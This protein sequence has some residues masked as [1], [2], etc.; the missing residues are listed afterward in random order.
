MKHS[1]FPFP[2]AARSRWL[3]WGAGLACAAVLAGCATTGAQD[4]SPEAQV[5]QRSAAYLKARQAGEVDKAYALLAPSY[6][7]V[8]NQERF[9]LEQGAATVLR[10]GDLVSAKCEETRCQVLRNYRTKVPM[11]GDAEVPLSIYETWVSEDGQW[12]LFME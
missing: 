4:Q 1:T 8:K 3:Q 7:A 2:L 11:M 9:R 10:G 6:R 12:W 5:T